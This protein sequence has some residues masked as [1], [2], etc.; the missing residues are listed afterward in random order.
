MSKD[1]LRLAM[2][3]Y[4]L[5]QAASVLDAKKV[6]QR[7][8]MVWDGR[9]MHRATEMDAAAERVMLDVMAYGMGWWQQDPIRATHIAPATI[10]KPNTPAE[11][12]GF[13]ERLIAD[14]FETRWRDTWRLSRLANALR[15]AYP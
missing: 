1:A 2:L 4:E 6:P 10:W 7:R 9:Q 15:A 12:D 14:D 3:A 11:V 5:E 8:R 13:V